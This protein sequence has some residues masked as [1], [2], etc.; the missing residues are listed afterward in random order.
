MHMIIGKAASSIAAS[1]K[2]CCTQIDVAGGA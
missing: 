2:I 1:F